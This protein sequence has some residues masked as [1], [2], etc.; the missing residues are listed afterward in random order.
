MVIGRVAAWLV[1][2]PVR[3]SM[4]AGPFHLEAYTPRWIDGSTQWMETALIPSCEFSRSLY[5]SM[6]V[7]DDRLRVIYYGPD[8]TK[9]D[10]A[11][12]QPADLRREFGWLPE[13]PL[14]GMIAYFYGELGVN[15]WTPSAV[16]GRSVK[17]QSDLIRAMPAIL[18]EFP[19]SKLLLIGSG[20]EEGGRRHLA[21]MEMLVNDLGLTDS[22]KFAGFRDDIPQVLRALDVAVQASLSENLGGSIEGLLMATPMVA[23]R[24][25]GLVD[26]VID[27]VTGVLAEPDNPQSLADAILRLLRDPVHARELALAGRALMLDK[28]TL[29]KTVEDEHALYQ[30]LLARSPAGYRIHRS[31]LRLI[32]G[33]GVS[34]YLAGR[35]RILDAALL[36]RLDS[37]WR[38]WHLIRLRLFVLR[39]VHA[40]LRKLSGR[41]SAA[42]TLP[43]LQPSSA[44]NDNGA[45]ALPKH[46]HSQQA[47]EQFVTVQPVEL[48]PIFANLRLAT[49]MMVYRL[50]ATVGRQKFGWSIRKK[51]RRLFRR[52]AA[53]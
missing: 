33:A 12:C 4:V 20:W 9:F 51:L 40:L 2:V 19:N 21:R 14:I 50:F 42:L 10:P 44:H 35:Y 27:D 1:D 5:K 29:R 31:L 25:G 11:R 22:V 17:C 37:G 8:E 52:R 48:P 39:I 30:E 41:Q 26:S 6:G 32:M 13:V 18:K 53:R 47:N 45:S 7:S 28:F 23:T 46:E 3:L 24:V 34:A 38:P 49:R 43:G 15:R 16:Q 36:P